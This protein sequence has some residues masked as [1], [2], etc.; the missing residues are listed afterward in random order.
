MIFNRQD[1]NQEFERLLRENLDALYRTALSL[2][3]NRLEAEELVQETSVRAF[4]FFDQYTPGTN[5]RGWLITVLKNIFINEYRRKTR[6]R[7]VMESLASE[8]ERVKPD[9]DL[10]EEVQAALDDLPEEQRLTLSLFYAEKLSYKEIAQ[11]MECPKGTV[12]S[13]LHVARKKL[14]ESV[15][16]RQRHRE[17]KKDEL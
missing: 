12:M 7:H 4:R 13:R 11:I 10:P 6:E 1:R 5:A 3:R 14:M 15:V 9:V 17:P 8:L 16:L 2:T